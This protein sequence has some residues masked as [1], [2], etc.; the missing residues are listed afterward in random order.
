MELGYLSPD[1]VLERAEQL[2]QTD[3]ADY[4]RRRARDHVD[5]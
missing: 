2:G 5:A 1:A 3:Y 4:L